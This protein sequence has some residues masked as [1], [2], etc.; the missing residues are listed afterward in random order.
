MKKS[1]KLALIGYGIAFALAIA[2]I[3]IFPSFSLTANISNFF[4][5]ATI[6]IIT[7]LVTEKYSSFVSYR[8]VDSKLDILKNKAP[9][10]FPYSAE[11]VCIGDAEDGV[12]YLAVIIKKSVIVKN[13]L[14]IC[15]TPKQRNFLH[16]Y[17]IT[18]NEVIVKNITDFVRN[19]NKWTDIFS[20]TGGKERLHYL[21]RSFKENNIEPTLII[22][23]YHCSII[24][25]DFPLIN[26]I[27]I[28]YDENKS[29]EVLFG[30]GLHEAQANGKVFSS[31]NSDIVD[32]FEK[33]FDS[34]MHVA[35]NQDVKDLMSL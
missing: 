22:K 16:D 4:E 17:T 18:Q 9:F 12:N 5:A 31:K 27:I 33:Y 15:L 14:F 32:Y 34:L 2:K 26:F 6:F 8:E 10:I 35:G 29:K 3:F 7:A 20:L 24:E 11:T 1:E 13:T 28:Q 25:N 23:K 19:G 30:W 21:Q